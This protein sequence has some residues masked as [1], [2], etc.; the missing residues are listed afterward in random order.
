MVRKEKCLYQGENWVKD[1][2]DFI[3]H[4]G[5]VTL[6]VDQDTFQ[7]PTSN[8]RTTYANKQHLEAYMTVKSQQLTLL[9]VQ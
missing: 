9:L 2:P 8:V 6:S 1:I 4:Q 3:D 7:L 5:F